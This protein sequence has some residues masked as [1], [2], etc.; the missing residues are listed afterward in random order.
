MP[1][2]HGGIEKNTSIMKFVQLN[3]NHCKVAQDVLVQTVHE[4]S[5]D[6]AI[7]CE[8]YKNMDGCNW[9]ADR[10]GKAAIW[11]CG[12]R[13]TQMS[14]NNPVAGFVRVETAGLHIYSCYA[15]PSATNEEFECF[16]D[17]LV[18]DV[19]LRKPV[20]IAGDF[21]AWATEWGSKETN[22]RG[23]SLLEAFSSMDVVLFN[24]GDTSTFR[25]GGASSVID[26]TFGSSCLMRVLTKWEVSENYTHSD[27]QAIF[28]EIKLAGEDKRI[29]HI[30]K[31]VGWK[32]STFEEDL[33]IVFLDNPN[34]SG[35][36]NAKATQLTNAITN[37]CSTTMVE[38]LLDTRRPPAYWWTERIAQLRRK[39]HHARRKHQRAWGTEA[40]PTLHGKYLDA[41]KQFKYAIKMRKRQ[42]WK[43][44]CEEINLDPWG[45]PYKIVMKRLKNP[46]ESP[47]DPV[48]LNKIVTV[49]FPQ[50][51]DVIPIIGRIPSLEEIPPVS[52]EEL[53]SACQ[54]VG[55]SKAPGPDNIPNIALKAA[56]RARPDKFRE[57][58]NS[59][60]R[61]G[62]FPEQWKRQR[63]VLLPKT[64]NP[65]GEPSSYRPLCMLNTAGKVLERII[66]NRLEKAVERAGDLAERQYGFRKARSTIHA[67]QHVVEIAKKG[68][69]GRSWRRGSKKYC[70]VVT[71]D[72]KNAFNSAKWSCILNALHAFQVP[73]YIRR[74]ISDYFRNRVLI[75][76]TDDGV[77][78]YNITGGVPQGSVLGPLLWNIMYD[79]I[80]RLR[81]PDEAEIVGFA[82]DVAVVVVAKTTEEITEIC[83][84]TI[85]IIKRWLTLSGLQLADHKTEAVLITSRKV[86]E[87]VSIDVGGMLIP[88]QPSLRYLGVEIDAR[89]NF[90]EHLRLVSRKASNVAA[91]LSRI[92]PNTGGSRQRRRMLLANVVT[93]I[94]L[95]GSPI[96]ADAMD[97]ETY[98]RSLI[99][100]YRLTALRVI[101]GFRTVS[102]DATFV[103]AG[104]IPIELLAKERKK[105]YEHREQQGSKASERVSTLNEW[106]RRWDSS[107]KGRWTYRLIPS[108]EKWINRGHGET[109]YYLTQLLSGHGC[110]GAYLHRFKHTDNPE[111]PACKGLQEDVEH[112]FFQCPRF[113]KTRKELSDILG[114]RPTPENLTGLMLVSEEKWNAVSHTAAEVLKELRRLERVRNEGNSVTR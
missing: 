2:I 54:R 17:Q 95:Y 93:S 16:L 96:W 27:H 62:I 20:I 19:R 77:M 100:V 112:I 84:L 4:A 40:Y 88:S 41:R 37:A 67:I 83:R 52:I 33:F 82:D 104:M 94:I 64:K 111:C 91:A 63:L 43:E 85:K 22:R 35:N 14:T 18:A 15:P 59:C 105:W 109:N 7:L 24:A 98:R 107:E 6:V 66:Y 86:K 78:E 87:T 12:R 47:T 3:L 56:I 106:Q 29:K 113:E 5:I 89:L 76:D 60:L 21:N 8:Q 102:N 57:V 28:F 80:L 36:A 65:S 1:G 92:M 70:A 72:I 101:C 51:T 31:P 97:F 23:M 90:K 26:L 114:Q 39:C 75:Y 34:L 110:F 50:Q 45:R 73:V 11:I 25:K 9:S 99:S 79:G 13:I 30:R 74:I 46:N 38:R 32:A 49:L 42:C 103:I 58:Y 69:H 48:M 44:L 108:I 53:N 68:I 55:N 61:E 71:L 81:V 10:T